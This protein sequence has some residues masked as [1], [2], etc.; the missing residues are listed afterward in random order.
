MDKKVGICSEIISFIYESSLYS[1]F[2]LCAMVIFL[3]EM[4]QNRNL[5]LEKPSDDCPFPYI[6]KNFA[7]KTKS[8]S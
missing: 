1:T 2:L 6:T 5:S 7:G 8:R 4:Y 3:L